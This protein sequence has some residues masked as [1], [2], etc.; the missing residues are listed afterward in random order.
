M[1]RPPPVDPRKVEPTFF[2]VLLVGLTFALAW[3]IEPFAGAVF[4]G[5]VLALL[6]EPLNRRLLDRMGRRRT[7][8]ALA[9]LLVILLIV[10]LPLAV[11]AASLTSEVAGMFQRIKTGEV[12]FGRYFEQ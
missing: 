10:V 12:D 2:T 9:T 1:T 4:W 6:F 7:L 5:A 11:V 3:V 8:A